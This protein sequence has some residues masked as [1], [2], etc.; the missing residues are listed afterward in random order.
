MFIA[1]LTFL[2]AYLKSPL[3]PLLLKQNKCKIKVKQ[4][5]TQFW[6]KFC[7]TNVPN[8][9]HTEKC[10]FIFTRKYAVYS[11]LSEKTFTFLKVAKT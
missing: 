10:R 2:S 7:L 4:L 1:F 6:S 9:K 3:S 8:L 5:S 11:T